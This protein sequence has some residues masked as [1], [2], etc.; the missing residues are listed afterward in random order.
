VGT[1][2]AAIFLLGLA[3]HRPL[4]LKSNRWVPILFRIV[5]LGLLVAGPS[6]VVSAR[7][8]KLLPGSVG[9]SSAKQLSVVADREHDF[10]ETIALT[11]RALRWAPLDWQLYLRRAIAEVELQQTANAVDDFRRA[12]FLEPTG[13]EIPLAEGNAWLPYHPS[14]TVT[15]WRDALRRA[16]PLRPEVYA[17]ML[18][19]ASLRSPEISHFLEV[20]SLE[21][22]DL[23]LPYLSHG[24]DASFNRVLAQLFKTDPNLQSFS[25]TEKLALFALWAERG[26]PEDVSRTVQQHPD[27]LRYAWA[28]MAK[29]KAGQKDFRG[30]YELTERYGEPVA[31]PR[32]AT[33]FSLQE[34]E[35]RFHAVPNNYGVGYELYRAQ[36]QKG[37]LDDALLTVRHFS[38]RPN[39]PAYFHFLEAKCW[40][41]KQN[42]ERAWYA[43]QAFQAAQATR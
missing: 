30:A 11:T 6:L 9:V 37:R 24:S 41:E 12:H 15:A 10:S 13:Y 18:G 3:L 40:A 19:D 25:E 21:E 2:F 29:Y 4:S 43:W 23:A 38:E 27:W 17:S 5:G 1:A 42:W 8:Q 31:L 28:G 7:G 33:N 32:V 26:D 20:I 36:M 39:S 14:L 22:H 35:K 34:L 16:G